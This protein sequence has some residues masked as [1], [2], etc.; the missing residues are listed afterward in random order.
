MDR[1]ILYKYRSLDG[2]NK[3]RAERIFTHSELYFPTPLQF[4]DP[5]D[6]GINLSFEGTR[7]EWCSYVDRI[8]SEQATGLSPA[9]RL[10]LR[11]RLKRARPIDGLSEQYIAEMMVKLGIFSLSETPVDILM[12]SHYADSHRGICIGFYSGP[13]DQFFRIF[14]AVQY[15]EDYPTTRVYDDV[16]QRMEAMLLTKS[17]HW[18]YERE[19]RIIDHEH[20]PGKKHFPS[21]LLACVILGSKIK[22][23]D[24]SDVIKWAKA[25]SAQPRILQAKKAERQFALDLIDVA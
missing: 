4:N 17:N 10:M 13:K 5:F 6:C 11:R 9:K 22:E 16:M 7:E 14:Q 24:R 19:Y 23:P 12:W 2:I 8:F 18:G 1:Q 25:H 15:Q 3:Q 20:G 21:E